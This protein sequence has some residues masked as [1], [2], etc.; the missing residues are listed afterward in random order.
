[1]AC[2]VKDVDEA[3]TDRDGEGGEKEE[4][5]KERDAGKRQGTHHVLPALHELLVDDL[6]SIVLAGLDVHGLLDDGVCT[7]SQS[8][9]GAILAGQKSQSPED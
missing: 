1:M 6:A 5:K 7:A 9:S 4:G 8:L 2:P 3:Q